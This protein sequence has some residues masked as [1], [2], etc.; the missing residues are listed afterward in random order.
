MNLITA[1]D[2]R[3]NELLN[4]PK[5]QEYLN[6]INENEQLNKKIYKNSS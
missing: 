5:V 4:D 6:L 3:I 2:K 1:N